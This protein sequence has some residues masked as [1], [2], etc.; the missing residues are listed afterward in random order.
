MKTKIARSGRPDK[1]PAAETIMSPNDHQR[2]VLRRLFDL[3]NEI[4]GMREAAHCQRWSLGRSLDSFL[5]DAKTL[6]SVLA[7]YAG[8]LACVTMLTP[9]LCE[10]QASM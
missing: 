7:T 9:E 6:R 2:A 4:D 5:D 10:R 8:C 3:V 1:L